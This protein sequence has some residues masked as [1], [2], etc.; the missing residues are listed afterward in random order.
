MMPGHEGQAVMA[1]M[2]QAGDHPGLGPTIE[3]IRT[4]GA[5]LHQ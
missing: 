1:V 2:T 4:S 5:Q 3:R